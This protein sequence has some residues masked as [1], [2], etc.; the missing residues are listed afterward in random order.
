MSAQKSIDHS[1]TSYSPTTVN[2]NAAGVEAGTAANPFGMSVILGGAAA[3]TAANPINVQQ[4]VLGAAG[5]TTSTHY[6][7]A[8]T[9][10][11][12]LV[13]AG[14]ARLYNVCAIN[15]SASDRFIK[16]YNKATAPVPGT[17]TPLKVFKVPA[18][19]VML[20]D[21]E[22]GSSFPLGIG[23]AITALIADLDATAIGAGEIVLD[24]DRA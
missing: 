1:P 7:S 9:T 6:T 15:T 12:T 5:G 10:N 2:V 8:A 11:A 23:F 19:G 18:N 20:W 21:M 4:V 17:D 13:K 24:L 22:I 14:A 3:G 16:F